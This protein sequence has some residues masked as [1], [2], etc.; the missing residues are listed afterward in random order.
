[1]STNEYKRSTNEYKRSTNEYKRSILNMVTTLLC[2][3]KMAAETFHLGVMD[4]KGHCN[5]KWRTSR[6]I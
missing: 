3:S 4:V 5:P 2:K 1:M 6:D